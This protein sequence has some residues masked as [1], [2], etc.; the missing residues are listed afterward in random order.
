VFDKTSTDKP[1]QYSGPKLGQKGAKKVKVSKKLKEKIMKVIEKKTEHIKGSVTNHYIGGSMAVT[2]GRAQA[3]QDGAGAYAHTS[4]SFT[5]PMFLDAA[6]ILFNN[7]TPVAVPGGISAFTLGSTGNF[8]A[9]NIIF[10][11]R[12][13]WTEFRIKNG[14]QHAVEYVLCVCAP[15]RKGSS[16]EW[17][18]GALSGQ[19]LAG[20]VAVEDAITNGLDSWNRSLAQD[21]ANGLLLPGFTGTGRAFGAPCI[22]QN[23][24]SSDL[25][26]LPANSTTM[27]NTF[28]IEEIKFFLQPGQM[29][30]HRVQGPKGITLDYG[31]FWANDVFQNIQ[32]FSRNY[33]GILYNSPNNVIQN[34]A[35]VF[36]GAQAG[37]WADNID[38]QAAGFNVQVERTDHY[39]IVLPE[40]AGFTMPIALPGVATSTP[41]DKR[42]PKQLYQVF[43]LSANTY[44]APNVIDLAVMNPQQPVNSS[45]NEGT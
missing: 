31:K 6:S 11:V 22:I 42:V 4:W 24:S 38:T 10:D 28:K 9:A 14:T 27:R 5:L 35:G 20:T 3:T 23:P 32:K 43:D 2:N 8:R 21:L 16:L 26:R 39:S 36:T 17:N 29:I 25:F 41:L 1:V 33:F 13:S 12:D 44:V 40:Q 37:R 19:T 30:I 34:T 7:K 45:N 18:S 15:K